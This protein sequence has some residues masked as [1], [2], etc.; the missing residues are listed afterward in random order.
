MK[1]IPQNELAQLKEQDKAEDGPALAN[2]DEKVAEEENGANEKILEQVTEVKDGEQGVGD[3]KEKKTS[4][5]KEPI[6]G[7]DSKQ[8]TKEEASEDSVSR[9]E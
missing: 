1:G 3:E 8:N 7:A 9:D 5:I 4:E 6:D 2:I